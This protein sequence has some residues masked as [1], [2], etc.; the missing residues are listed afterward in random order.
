MKGTPWMIVYLILA[1]D[2]NSLRAVHA[3]ELHHAAMPNRIHISWINETGGESSC[4]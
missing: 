1:A 4:S 3:Q 2:L